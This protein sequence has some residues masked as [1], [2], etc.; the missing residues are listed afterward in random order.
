MGPAPASERHGRWE[1]DPALMAKRVAS[2][3][4]GVERQDQAG[5]PNT[6]CGGACPRNPPGHHPLRPS[7]QGARRARMPGRA[8]VLL[9]GR[10][11]AC[12]ARVDCR[13]HAPERWIA[14]LR[15]AACRRTVRGLLRR[16]DTA[17]PRPRNPGVDDALL[18]RPHHS[19]CERARGCVLGRASHKKSG[20]DWWAPSS[21]C[22]CAASAAILR[23]EGCPR[24]VTH[25]D[26]TSIALCRPVPWCTVTWCNAS[27]VRS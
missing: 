9:A 5:A 2:A 27:A 13:A 12:G 24:P 25:R 1:S 20:N 26:W 21:A 22:H 14:A 3:G 8:C 16:C 17:A 11:G 19:T 10:G 18:G 7:L 15:A 6:G 23:R 4:G